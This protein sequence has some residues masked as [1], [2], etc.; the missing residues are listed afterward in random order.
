M[1]RVAGVLLL[2]IVSV[3]LHPDPST[4]LQ[5]GP[6]RA[7]AQTPAPQATFRGGTDL[8]QVDVSVLDGKRHPVRGLTAGDFTIFEDGQPREIQAFSEVDLP[9]RLQSR[10]ASWTRDVPSDVATNQAVEHEGR[11]VI[12]LLDRTIPVG[13]PTIAARRIAAAA[14]NQ[15]GPGDL[16]AVVS[17]SNGAVQNL[18]SDRT[19]LLRAIS[20][21]DL[22]TDISDEAREIEAAVFALTGRTWSTLNDGRCQCG[23]CVL[24]TITHVADAV[25]GPSRRR[26][27]LF[28]IGSD[29]LL[30]AADAP[31]DP[32]ND[33]GCQKRLKDARATMF[34]AVDRANLTIHSL[35][36]SGLANV[37]PTTRASSTLR[38][39]SGPFG[40]AAVTASTGENLRRQGN[41]QVLPDRTGGRAVMNTNGA[42]LVVPEIFRESDSYYLIGFRSSDPSA[43]GKFHQITVKTTRRGLD[44]RARSGYTASASVNPANLAAANGSLSEP[45]REALTGLLPE[46]ATSVDLNTATFAVA[47]TRKVAVVLT[48][49]VAGFAAVRSDGSGAQRGS[50]LEI[51]ATAFDPGGRPTAMTRQSLELS[52]PA[53][54]ATGERRFDALSRLDLTP[55]EYEVRVAVS[56]AERTASVF[57]YLTVP[58]FDSAPLS[59]SNIVTGATAGTLT[60]PKDFLAPLL[61]IVPTARREFARSDRLV[62]FFRIYQGTARQDPLASVQVRSAIVDAQGAVVA[63]ETKTMDAGQFTTG[64]AADYYVTLPLTTLAPGEY[65]LRVETTMGSRATGRAMRFVVKP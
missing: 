15:I 39:G 11:L 25:Q 53:S 2:A 33:V 61:P 29:L 26:K 37:S 24:E 63:S 22:S 7:G 51:V 52:W 28:F 47:G 18:T 5:V 21:T 59:L 8:V 38:P 1:T 3:A 10:D 48:V 42:D 55:G 31:G 65:L 49:G 58:A 44:V 27:V 17:T 62:A 45:V 19:R 6:L 20:E 14:I 23:L 43:N 36:P 54:A 57:S 50:P 46:A 32:A 64:R 12:I 40:A 16:A 30:Q 60:A 35:D 9:D 41:L 4:R 34:T 56:G 13:E